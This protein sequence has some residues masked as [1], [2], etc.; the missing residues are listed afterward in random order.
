[1]EFA[2]LIGAAVKAT[3]SVKKF[4]DGFKERDQYAM[5]LWDALQDLG[6]QLQ[7]LDLVDLDAAR[8]QTWQLE[9]DSKQ[10]R[11]T[12]EKFDHGRRSLFDVLS[13]QDAEACGQCMAGALFVKAMLA[14]VEDHNRNEAFIQSTSLFA[15]CKAAS[16]HD[17]SYFAGDTAR[18]KAVASF[19][20]DPLWRATG[21]FAHGEDTLSNARWFRDHGMKAVFPGMPVYPEWA[22]SGAPVI[23]YH[24]HLLALEYFLDKRHLV[25]SKKCG[26]IIFQGI[27]A[28]LFDFSGTYTPLLL[29]A[30]AGHKALNLLDSLSS[31]QCKVVYHPFDVAFI[32]WIAKGRRFSLV[33]ARDDLE[34]LAAIPRSSVSSW[35][36]AQEWVFVF[37][38]SN[39]TLPAVLQAPEPPLSLLRRLGEYHFYAMASTSDV[40][41][42]ASLADP[43]NLQYKKDEIVIVHDPD[44][45]RIWDSSSSPQSLWFGGTV[46]GREVD[47]FA[48]YLIPIHDHDDPKYARS[49]FCGKDNQMVIK[50]TPASMGGDEVEPVMGKYETYPPGLLLVGIDCQTNSRWYDPDDKV[51]FPS[52][53]VVVVDQSSGWREYLSVVLAAQNEDGQPVS[54]DIAMY[55]D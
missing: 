24:E 19:V 44:F 11:S 54:V 34:N 42:K 32:K 31:K 27:E 16:G 1:M 29:D 12:V 2:H 47:I 20:Y 18:S 30:V 35:N 15:W 3:S 9:N 52:Q 43:A 25:K 40:F 45:T 7:R 8:S 5:R 39:N 55:W 10:Q 14:N 17:L 26:K 21:K 22:G 13:R 23:S 28:S 6:L 36:A 41:S 51:S 50:T 48:K 4:V 53:D 37:P 49:T 38:L 46:R 33:S